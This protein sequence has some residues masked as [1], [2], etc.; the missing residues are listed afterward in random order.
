MASLRILAVAA[1]AG[2]CTTTADAQCNV[3]GTAS[4]QGKAALT[5]LTFEWAFNAGADKTSSV[6]V[7]TADGSL[8]IT[9]PSGVLTEASTVTVSVL[10]S[11][12]ASDRNTRARRKSGK[13]GFGGTKFGANTA[14]V[15]DGESV[16]LHTSCSQPFFLGTTVVQFA[17]GRLT[18]VGF[19]SVDVDGTARSDADCGPQANLTTAPAATTTPCTSGDE[20]AKATKSLCNACLEGGGNAITMLRFQITAG[21]VA[22]ANSQMNA[23]TVSGVPMPTAP[24]AEPTNAATTTCGLTGN[25]TEIVERGVTPP[26][27][28]P[29][30]GQNFATLGD[31]TQC[32]PYAASLVCS[33]V[34]T[35]QEYETI[36]LTYADISE[37]GENRVNNVDQNGL[38]STVDFSGHNSTSPLIRDGGL[39]II[40]NNGN[41]I[42]GSLT[43]TA[44]LNLNI[45]YFLTTFPFI[46][47]SLASHVCSSMQIPYNIVNVAQIDGIVRINGE[48]VPCAV[49][50]ASASAMT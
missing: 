33:D 39:V 21:A 4:G 5:T 12:P 49:Q 45:S 15:V 50:H 48:Q 13:T 7:S 40:H 22:L 41:S 25:L 35:G 28:I 8:S 11:V 2:L 31:L 34:N 10:V 37:L 1:A 43:C 27:T 42:G 16:T 17:T 26:F 30:A 36:S 9:P 29:F 20:A 19:G 44:A 47:G 18:L 38:T 32:E 46:R 6:Q 3:C 14:F 23:S 24:A